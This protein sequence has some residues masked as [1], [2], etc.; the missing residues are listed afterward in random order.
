MIEI[1]EHDGGCLLPVRAQPGA[2]KTG[3][4]GE[5]AGA[6][7]VAVTVA[8]EQGKANKAL[9]DVLVK[10]LHLKKA[11]VELFSGQTSRDKRILIRGLTA[12]ELLT[13][14]DKVL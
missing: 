12:E 4:A 9:V 3:I 13:A 8:P 6:L 11:Q 5:H 2:K 10:S 7:K 1:Q 14:I